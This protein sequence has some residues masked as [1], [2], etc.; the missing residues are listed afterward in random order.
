MVV[1]WQLPSTR[2][3]QVLAGQRERLFSPYTGARPVSSQTATLK[4]TITSATSGTAIVQRIGE[5]C[6]EIL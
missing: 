5:C 2:E 3:L 1:M 4:E 6:I